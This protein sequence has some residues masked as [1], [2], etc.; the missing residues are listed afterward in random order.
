LAEL[1]DGDA[2]AL[3]AWY[4]RVPE[5]RKSPDE[6]RLCNE[7]VLAPGPGGDPLVGSWFAR[8]GRPGGAPEILT[9]TPFARPGGDFRYAVADRDGSFGEGTWRQDGEAIVLRRDGGEDV[10]VPFRLAERLLVL[11]FG[12]ESVT[13]DSRYR[14]L[15]E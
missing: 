6:P 12:D 13:Y 7:R 4:A 1:R 5:A 3:E 11:R 8:G 15:F 2:S 14:G 9:L 10:R